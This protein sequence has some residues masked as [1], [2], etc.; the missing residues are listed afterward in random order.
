[1]TGQA[2]D[3]RHAWPVQG[4]VANDGSFSGVAGGQPLTGR[5]AGTGFQG[6]YQSQS[7][8]CGSRPVALQ[9]LAGP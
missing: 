5:F 1:M 2:T 4:M 7:P 6:S 9:R 3:G 8:L